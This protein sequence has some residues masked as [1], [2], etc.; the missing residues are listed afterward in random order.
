MPVYGPLIDGL[1]AT[2]SDVDEL[3]EGTAVELQ[4]TCRPMTADSVFCVFPLGPLEQPN[5][6][7]MPTCASGSSAAY[8]LVEPEERGELALVACGA[9][10]PEGIEAHANLSKKSLARASSC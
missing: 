8:W 3:A 6:P 2:P 1:S 5:R 10:L 9:L 4:A 7:S